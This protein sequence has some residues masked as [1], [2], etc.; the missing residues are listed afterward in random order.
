MEHT[1]IYILLVNYNNYNDTIDCLNSLKEISYEDI[2]V[3]IVDNNSNNKSVD[4]LRMYKENHWKHAN[5]KLTIICS[6]KN[7]GFAGGNNIGIDFFLEKNDSEYIVLLN[8][9]TIVTHNF[10]EPLVIEAQ[11]NIGTYVVTGT[12]KHYPETTR[13]WYNGGKYFKLFSYVVHNK[14]KSSVTRQVVSFSSGCL[15]LIKKECL[16]KIGKLNEDYFMYY[17]DLDYCYRVNKAK[18]EIVIRRDSIIYHKIG[19]SNNT[20]LSNFSAYWM[21]RNRIKFILEN[22]TF[23]NRLISI[24]GIF[25]SRLPIF[26]YRFFLGQREII[27]SQIKGYRDALIYN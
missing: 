2:H 26:L 20:A 25:I 23:T 10:L 27:I 13:Y 8:N 21:A 9:D 24:M 11:Y 17:E 16:E 4:E 22:L 18:K 5:K 3:L 7:L 1:K 19:A 6:E 12:I 14:N 15:M